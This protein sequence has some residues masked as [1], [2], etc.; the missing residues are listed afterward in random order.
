MP[1]FPVVRIARVTTFRNVCPRRQH[2]GSRVGALCASLAPCSAGLDKLC[3]RGVKGRLWPREALISRC[4]APRRGLPVQQS[5]WIRPAAGTPPVAAS[6]IARA[7]RGFYLSH[8]VTAL[9]K[10][11]KVVE[12]ERP[13]V[14][15]RQ[16]HIDSATAQPAHSQSRV[17]LKFA[18]PT[19]DLFAP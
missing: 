17:A 5:R 1:V 8:E 18:P 15:G 11:Y 19:G 13:T 9:A 6:G 3:R 16:V 7:V 12:G 10:G 14:S 4:L 2:R